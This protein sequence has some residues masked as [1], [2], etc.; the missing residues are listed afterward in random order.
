MDNNCRSTLFSLLQ[1]SSYYENKNEAFDGWFYRTNALLEQE[2]NLSKN[3]LS[4]ALD[5]LYRAGI[6][7]IIPQ[8]KGKGKVQGA[9]KYKVNYETFLKYQSIPFEECSCSH[10]DFGIVTSD[11]K[12]GVPSFQLRHQLEEQPKSGKSDNNIDSI[13][14]TEI[15]DNI[16]NKDIIIIDNS[17]I[18]NKL[19]ISSHFEVE[20]EKEEEP[21]SNYQGDD[22]MMGDTSTFVD[23]PEA[24]VQTPE[25]NNPPSPTITAD[26]I[27]SQIPFVYSKVNRQ[28]ETQEL[29]NYT[30][31]AYDILDEFE[32]EVPNWIACINSKAMNCDSAMTRLVETINGRQYS[33][34]A[35]IEKTALDLIDYSAKVE[36]QYARDLRRMMYNS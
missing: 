21:H 16:D 10:P 18:N 4:G 29:D 19:D 3:V 24:S 22:A 13:N 23:N 36:A 31:E 8:A 26:F 14:N 12:K 20:T 33:S 2:T 25:D 1:L 32:R 30:D 7:D 35:E 6:I 11:Y 28:G 34:Q 9:R 27:D 17:I 15:I 5:S